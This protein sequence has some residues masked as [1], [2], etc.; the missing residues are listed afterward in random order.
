[1]K[2][3]VI[4]FVFLSYLLCFQ[5]WGQQA[6]DSISS[7]EW[8]IGKWNI[9][10]VLEDSEGLTV[11]ESGFREC[12]WV[13]GNRVIRCDSY[14]RNEELVDSTKKQFRFLITYISYNKSKNHY[15]VTWIRTN[16][17][18]TSVV[19]EKKNAWTLYSEYTYKPPSL[20][21]DMLIKDTISKTDSNHFTY[22]EILENADNSFRE[23]FELKATRLE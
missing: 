19:F 13:L 14:L 9:S 1:M 12:S 22:L 20:G 4:S 17:N 2:N 16:G 21:F 8:M 11:T 15:K 7:L 6:T 18:H 5:V 10:A 23:R 3:V